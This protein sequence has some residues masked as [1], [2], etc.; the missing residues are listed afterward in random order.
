[1]SAANRFRDLLSQWESYEA[2]DFQAK[3]N[4]ILGNS[5]AAWE[6]GP[7]PADESTMLFS[8]S[9]VNDPDWIARVS[10]VLD[11]PFQHGNVS[12]VLGIPPR[13]WERYF[14]YTDQNNTVHKI[15][16]DDWLFRMSPA[17]DPNMV[18]L[19]ILADLPDSMDWFETVSIMLTGELGEI[20]ISKHI[21]RIDRVT[22]P[23][24]L[25]PLIHLRPCFA[26][27]FPTCAYRDFILSE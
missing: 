17:D 3:I 8:L 10:A 24:D 4:D 14:E 12:A 21:D 6:F 20:N 25:A 11:I 16:G 5:S 18:R 2:D 15:D 1:M 22:K 26:K 19:K 13:H 23:T 7:D 27:K 9:I